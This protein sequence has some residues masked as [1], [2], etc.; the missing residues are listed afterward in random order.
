[1]YFKTKGERYNFLIKEFKE[2]HILS[3]LGVYVVR[4]YMAEHIV[5]KL[6]KPIAKQWDLY[7]S[8]VMNN[9]FFGRPKSFY[10]WID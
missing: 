3:T 1:M 10:S 4:P 8:Y 2:V 5:H 6:G 7:K 9:Q